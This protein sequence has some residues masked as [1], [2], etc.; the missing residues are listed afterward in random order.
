MANA[1]LVK[2]LE[3]RGDGKPLSPGE[4]DKIKADMIR[5]RAIA[6]AV[7]PETSGEPRTKTPGKTGEEP[8]E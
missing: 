7:K 4:L 8:K 2:E 6:G 1:G 5:D 3:T